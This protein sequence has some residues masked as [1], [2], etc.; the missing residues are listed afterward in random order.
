MVVVVAVVV[1]VVVVVVLPWS[2]GMLCVKA[3]IVGPLLTGVI[4]DGIGTPKLLPPPEP[5]LWPRTLL[6]VVVLL[7]LL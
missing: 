1:V 3:D 5:S 4:S 2:I 6:S 7:L